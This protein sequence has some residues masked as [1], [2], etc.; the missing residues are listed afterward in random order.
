MFVEPFDHAAF[1]QRFLESVLCCVAN[2]VFHPLDFAV[3]QCVYDIAL[4]L[5]NAIDERGR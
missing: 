1:Q 2:G 4:R 5:A 3:G